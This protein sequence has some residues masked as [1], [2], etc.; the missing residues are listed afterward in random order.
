MSTSPT[1]D[2]MQTG[3]FTQE[4]DCRAGSSYYTVRCAWNKDSFAFAWAR[5]GS[6]Q[7]VFRANVGVAGL[8]E[9]FEWH[10]T[11]AEGSVASRVPYL[12]TSA[13]GTKTVTVNQTANAGRWNSLGA[14]RFDRGRSGQ[15]VISAQ[16]ADGTVLADAIKLVW[17]GESGGPTFADVPLD[18]WAYPYIEALY[19]GRFVAGCA[20]SPLRYCPGSELKR[21]EAAVFVDRG[22]H[23]ADFTPPVPVASSFADVALSHWAVEWIETLWDDSLTAGCRT[24]PLRYCPEGVHTRAEATVFFERILRGKDYVPPEP[25]SVYY[26]DVALGTWYAKWV[27]AAYSDQLTPACEDAA[28]RG[29]RL[30]RP[31]EP[32]SRAEAACMM[33]QAK[34]LAAP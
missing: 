20:L 12:I 16:G 32:I 28:N 6:A 25:S 5:P 19:E 2:W 10:G 14:Y 23:G 15:V 13:E 8:Y 26:T 22:T 31:D 11:L 1:N 9:V 3:G 4:Q 30:F 24:Q 21:S 27:A 18:H 33:A 7:A 17:L 34:G 29:D